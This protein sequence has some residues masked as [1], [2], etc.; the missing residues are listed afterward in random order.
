[1]GTGRG[2]AQYCM[3]AV[4]KLI[5][6]KLKQRRLTKSFPSQDRCELIAS[7]NTPF[8]R[9]DSNMSV[10]SD[11]ASYPGRVCHLTEQLYMIVMNWIFQNH[12]VEDSPFV[13]PLYHLNIISWRLSHLSVQNSGCISLKQRVSFEGHAMFILYLPCLTTLPGN[14]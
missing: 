6:Q 7:S 13:L 8:L 12:K 10:N 11:S 2:I 1:M 5:S 3:A 4:V 9:F 14:E